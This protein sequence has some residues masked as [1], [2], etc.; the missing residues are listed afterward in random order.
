M[1]VI[2][3]GVGFEVL[4]HLATL[5]AIVICLRRDVLG[6]LR[7]VLRLFR[8]LPRG[9]AELPREV[10][11][12]PGGA[13]SGEVPGGQAETSG[14]R[15]E[16]AGASGGE[17]PGSIPQVRGQAGGQRELARRREKRQ[18]AFRDGVRRREERLALAVIVGTIPAAVA[19]LLF[20]SRF[21]A[22]FS[23]PDWAGGFLL[24]TGAVLLSTRFRGEGNRTLGPG[25]G[26]LIGIAQAAALLPGISR[27]GFTIAAAILLGVPRGEAVR[28]SFMLALPAMGGAL[29]YTTL[30]AEGSLFEAAPLPS[31]VAF[32]AALASGSAAILILLRAVRRGRFELFGFYCLIVGALAIAFL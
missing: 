16:P 20:G 18:G 13:R 8:L 23:R 22:A 7:G 29:L 28:F 12:Q 11:Q 2:G 4:V 32:A 3:S 31:A 6:L 27:S 9:F 17:G 24:V 30:L 15:D 14:T 1:D 19:G 10:N 26:F 5:A 25:V 21:E